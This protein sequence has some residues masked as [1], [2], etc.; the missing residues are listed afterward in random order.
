MSSP[1]LSDGE[2]EDFIAEQKARLQRERERVSM[3]QQPDAYPAA[4][5]CSVMTYLVLSKF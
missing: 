1:T 3:Q 2:L 5:S 4:V